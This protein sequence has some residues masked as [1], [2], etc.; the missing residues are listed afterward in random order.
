MS[1][2]PFTNSF[3]SNSQLQKFLDGI[4]DYASV[5]IGDLIDDPGLS[6]ELVSELHNIKGQ[7][8]NTNRFAFSQSLQHAQVGHDTDSNSITSSSDIVGNN[9][10]SKDARGVK[11]IEVLIQPHI[12]SGFLD[13]IFKSVDFFHQ[14]SEKENQDLERML[15]DVHHSR[16][17]QDDGEDKDP[18][19]SENEESESEEGARNDETG[20]STNQD[21]EDEGEDHESHQDKMRRCVQV[22]A[23]V[24]SIDLWVISNRII[25]TPVIINKLWSIVYLDNLVE[26]SPSVNHIVRI[27][28]Q[29]MNTNAIELLNYIRNRDDLVDMFL[30]KLEVPMLM[31]FFLRVIQSD[32]PDSP[33]G[34]I[35]TLYAQDLVPKLIEILKPHSSQF[36]K[37]TT[38]IPN[39]ELIFKQT[40]ATDFIKALITISSN[41][42]LAV[43]VDANVGPNQLTRQLVSKQT[44]EQFVYDIM[45]YTVKDPKTGIKQTNKHGINNCVGIVIELIRKNNSDYDLNCGSYSSLLQ[46]TNGEPTEVNPYVMFQWLK[47]FEQ[48]IPGPKDPIYL[49]E[50]LAI[51]SDNLDKFCELLESEPELPYHTSTNSHMLGFSKFRIAELIAELLHCSNMVLNNSKKI[52]KIV[53]IRDIIRDKQT[54]RLQKAL[55]ET[56]SDTPESD[57]SVEDISHDVTNM[58]LDERSVSSSKGV[59]QN[60]DALLDGETPDFIKLIDSLDIEEESDDE[61]PTISTDNP[62]V[63][64]SRDATIRSDPCVGDYFKIKLIDSKIMLN[65]ISKFTE[66]PWHNFFHN[67]VFD[68]IQQIFNGKLN[69]YNSFLIS[70]LFSKDETNLIKVIV[71]AYKA[72]F[73]LRP[74]YL[75]HLI[76]IS[77]EVVKFTSL[78]KPDLISPLIVEAV[79]SEEWTWFVSDILLQTREVYNVVLGADP[80]DKYEYAEGSNRETNDVDNDTH[81]YGFDSS[82]VGFL[83]MG[84]YQGESKSKSFLGHDDDEGEN[85]SSN[86]AEVRIQDMTPRL[87]KLAD[88]EGF[89]VGDDDDHDVDHFSQDGFLE[90]LSESSS[91]DD[92]DDDLATPS[93][94]DDNKL[95]RVKNHNA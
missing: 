61:E 4:Q 5:S 62:F 42:A 89:G 51:F 80:S 72:D 82:T 71:N 13:Y 70:H 24:L 8:N 93:S 36:D 65:I 53:E 3:N 94:P 74:G 20:D 67:V 76:L 30:S 64:E 14:L 18:E 81:E 73:D 9:S 12:L 88:T 37:T 60:I 87:D 47:D 21:E 2:W 48:N 50:M 26:S 46:T 45:L 41:T 68:L 57:I 84:N 91:S 66:Y 83:D 92:D 17:I 23:D 90:N 52:R 86:V 35:D 69:S 95:T 11:L 32:K 44:I 55:N 15:T 22:A 49:G 31:D 27:L 29:L 78:Y 59:R 7:Y 34:I 58:S 25:E 40:A 85:D 56:F 54:Q 75:G 10:S 28:D 79:S 63:C 77:E 43:A 33:T 19:S 6:Q 38:T 16:S 39:H 1:F